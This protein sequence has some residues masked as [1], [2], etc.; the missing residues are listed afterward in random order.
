VRGTIPSPDDITE[1]LPEEPDETTE[2][3]AR[4]H[5]AAVEPSETHAAIELETADEVRPR[6]R[7]VWLWLAASIAIAS[8]WLLR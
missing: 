5:V 6:V 2:V 7:R 3:Q 4:R 1:R 8:S